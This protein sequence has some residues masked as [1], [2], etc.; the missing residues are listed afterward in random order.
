MLKKK[1]LSNIKLLIFEAISK[2]YLMLKKTPKNRFAFV[3]IKTSYYIC[4]HYFNCGLFQFPY[5]MIRLIIISFEQRIH[6]SDAVPSQID[7]KDTRA[8]SVKSLLTQLVLLINFFLLNKVSLNRLL[9]QHCYLY[10][11][12]GFYNI[13]I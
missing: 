12:T 9:N 8:R 4:M 6:I 7:D 11:N 1:C 3:M 5:D 13:N 2:H 10:M